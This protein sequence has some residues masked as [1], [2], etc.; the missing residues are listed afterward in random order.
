MSKTRLDITNDFYPYIACV[1]CCCF[2][3]FSVHIHFAVLLIPWTSLIFP[4]PFCLLIIRQWGCQVKGHSPEQTRNSLYFLLLQNLRNP[5]LGR[6]P[7]LNSLLQHTL[8]LHL[9]T[10]TYF[11]EYKFF[12]NINLGLVGSKVA[13]KV[14]MLQRFISC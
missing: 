6:G 13:R 1:F 4:Y 2:F 3:L 8:R 5:C 10:G 12:T 7:L 14:A 11:S 9:L